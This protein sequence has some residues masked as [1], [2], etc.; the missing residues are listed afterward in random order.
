MFP[1]L[2]RASEQWRIEKGSNDKNTRHHTLFPLRH[3]FRQMW[4]NCSY[5]IT[6]HKC[7][8]LKSHKHEMISSSSIAVDEFPL[9]HNPDDAL[10]LLDHAK[11]EDPSVT[12]KLC[13]LQIFQATSGDWRNQRLSR[14][15]STAAPSETA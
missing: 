6:L 10:L 15:L 2:T 5:V 1:F 4:E 7:S 8:L 12:V 3:L 14:D 13:R 11:R 9:L